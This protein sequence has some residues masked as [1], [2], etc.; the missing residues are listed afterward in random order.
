MK[1]RERLPDRRKNW[2]QK[3]HVDGQSV[4]FTVGLYADGRPGEIFIDL[5]RTGAALRKWA[6]DTAMLFSIALQHGCD[7]ETL[8]DLFA[9]SRCE[10]C[11]EVRGHPRITRCT[12]VMDFI[13]R[14][15]ALE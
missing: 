14:A 10:P 8:V 7:L 6:C 15:L 3:A 12:S 4:H 9:G 5:A 2:T 13:A 1:N 11:G